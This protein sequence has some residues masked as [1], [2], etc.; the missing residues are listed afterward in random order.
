MVQV[1]EARVSSLLKLAICLE[2]LFRLW[3]NCKVRSVQTS[4][5]R[6]AGPSGQIA[7]QVPYNH[8]V[9]NGEAGLFGSAMG[10]IEVEMGISF[11]ADSR[12][13][14]TYAR[15]ASVKRIRVSYI[16]PHR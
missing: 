2:T 12:V 5:R 4:E 6:C 15:F 14:G 1:F 3:L 9:L 7:F 13:L 10:C 11:L 8:V 16:M